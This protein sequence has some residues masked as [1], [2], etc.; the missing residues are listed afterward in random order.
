MTENSLG[1]QL[2]S[3]AHKVDPSIAVQTKKNAVSR[4]LK[5]KRRGRQLRLNLHSNF[6]SINFKDL[7]T[8]SRSITQADIYYLLIL[9]SLIYNK[10]NP[11]C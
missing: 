8:S 2:K 4:E 1:H 5:E 9:W 11:T 7:P 3:I 10:I 6:L